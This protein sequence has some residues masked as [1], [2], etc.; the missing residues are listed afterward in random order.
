MSQNMLESVLSGLDY[1]SDEI[2]HQCMADT[3]WC[4]QLDDHAWSVHGKGPTTV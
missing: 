4:C 1:N 3:V 2:T